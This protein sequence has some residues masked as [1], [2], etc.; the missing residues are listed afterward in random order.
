LGVVLGRRGVRA[1][2]E[3]SRAGRDDRAAEPAERPDRLAGAVADVRDQLD[4][5]RVQLALDG[6]VD[7]AEPVEDRPGGVRLPTGDGVDEEQLLLD[8]DR[9][10]VP[11]PEG[12]A[13]LLVTGRQGPGRFRPPV[14]AN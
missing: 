8:A 2:A 12:V 9:E 14:A 3:H 11:R 13:D 7:R 6:A 5:A 4:L 1:R 10:R